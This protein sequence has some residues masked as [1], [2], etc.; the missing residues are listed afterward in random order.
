MRV[1]LQ[2]VRQSSRMRA[3]LLR[4]ALFFLHST[5]LL[6]LLPLV[7]RSLPGGQAGT[8]TVLLASMGAGA[9]FAALQMQ[10]LR[11][12][13]RPQTLLFAGTVLQSAAALVVAFAPS[14]YVAVPA[15]VFAG[16]AWI[17]VA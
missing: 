2:Y 14:I 12:L 10:R 9:I 4:I 16:M 13:L 15:M 11:R 1:G 17:T 5:A 8:F 7:A 6:A 3:I